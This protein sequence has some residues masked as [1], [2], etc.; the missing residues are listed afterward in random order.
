MRTDISHLTRYGT[1]LDLIKGT[2]V[3]RLLYMRENHQFHLTMNWTRYGTDGYNRSTGTGSISE[4][5]P[6]W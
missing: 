5:P 6:L 3:V 2:T 1:Q 4:P